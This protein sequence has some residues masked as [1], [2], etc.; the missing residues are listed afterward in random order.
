MK[1]KFH[2]E[3]KKGKSTGWSTVLVDD[4]ANARI[5]ESPFIKPTKP[6]LYAFLI[7][8]GPEEDELYELEEG[9]SVEFVLEDDNTLSVSPVS[10]AY[11]HHLYEQYW[12][13]TGEC[14][15]QDQKYHFR[16]SYSPSLSKGYIVLGLTYHDAVTYDP[17]LGEKPRL[18]HDAQS[19]LAFAILR[20]LA[21]RQNDT[22]IIFVDEAD[23]LWENRSD[24]SS[25]E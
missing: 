16:A 13:V 2:G 11:P 4:L 9:Q 19:L 5:V 12:F 23:E 24:H 22:T 25:T 6:G 10:V 18:L 14:V 7:K 3:P 15:F 17:Y 20:G 8:S 1:M 21:R